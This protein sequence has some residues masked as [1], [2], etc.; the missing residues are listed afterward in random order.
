M[1]E[2]NPVLRCPHLRLA[3][4]IV[5]RFTSTPLEDENGWSTA[6]SA[7]CCSTAET[8]FPA[9]FALTRWGSLVLT[10]PPGPSSH[11]VSPRQR[12]EYSNG[13]DPNSELCGLSW[14]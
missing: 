4:G 10:C 11:Y 9:G 2:G 14:L 8:L 5:L 7:Y 1:T 13:V 12:F 3:A 6:T